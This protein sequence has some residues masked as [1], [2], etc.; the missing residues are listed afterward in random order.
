MHGVFDFRE[1]N[2]LTILNMSSEATETHKIS[3]F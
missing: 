3:K 1:K 2:G